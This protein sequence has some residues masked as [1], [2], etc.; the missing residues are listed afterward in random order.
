M[1]RFERYRTPLV[2]AVL[3]SL[4]ACDRDDA[5]SPDEAGAEPEPGG[6]AVLAEIADLGIPSPLVAQTDLDGNLSA[7]V[8]YMELVR[9]KWEDGRLVYQTADESPMALARSYEYL[10]PDSSALRFRLRSD[11]LW[12]DGVPIT[13]EDVAFTYGLI[14]DPVLASPRSDA[15]EQLDSVVVENDSTV[16]FHFALRYPDMLFHS[17]VPIVPRHVFEGRAAADFRSHPALQNPVGNLVVSGPFMIGGWRKGQEITLVRNPHFRPR[18]HL[19]RIVFRIVPE[20]TTR[21]TELRTGAVDF[22]K[23]IPFDQIPSLAAQAPHVRFERE[24]QRNYDYVAYNPTGFVAFE[25]PEIRRALGLAINVPQMIQALQMEEYTEPAGGPYAP[26]FAELYDPELTPPLPH[27]PDEA[28]RILESRGWVDSNGD[29]I[30]EKDGV[31][32]RFSLVTNA[33]NPRRADASQMIQQQWRQVGVDARLRVT[34]F[35]S[36]MSGLFGQ[37]YEAALGGWQVGLSPDVSPLFTS[38]SPLN[39]TGMD[40]ARVDSLVALALR[41]PTPGAAARTWKEAG[42]AIVANRPYTWLYYLDTVDGVNE[43][44]RGMRIDTYGAY[45]NAWE[46]WIPRDLQ[47]ARAAADTTATGVPDTPSITAPDTAG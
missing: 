22:V 41:E 25:D 15:V 7:D 12:S 39:I 11:A 34:E 2:A 5:R 43:R 33:G 18:P 16:V 45:Q 3:I 8:L 32:F 26:I 29:G 10:P 4:A 23:A 40:D 37:E 1:T 9:G 21:L 28:R 20:P 38:G 6:T 42:A 35:N 24:R 47:R 17:A 27:D 36:F 19:D 31:P 46:W 13:A 30:R 44:L 14:E